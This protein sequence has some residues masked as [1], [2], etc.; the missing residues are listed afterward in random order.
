MEQ[1][2]LLDFEVLKVCSEGPVED[3]ER[4]RDPSKQ[5]VWASKRMEFEKFES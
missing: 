4:L 2:S 1:E 5:R 3:C